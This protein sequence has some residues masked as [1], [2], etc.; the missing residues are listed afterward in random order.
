M[1]CSEVA[2][3]VFCGTRNLTQVSN[4]PVKMINKTWQILTKLIIRQ[5]NSTFYILKRHPDLG[6]PFH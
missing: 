4:L 1:G 6:I 2:K 3:G 5:N